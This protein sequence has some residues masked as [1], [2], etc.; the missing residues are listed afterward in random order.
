MARDFHF[1]IKEFIF[2]IEIQIKCI[3]ANNFVQLFYSS[4]I[5]VQI[6]KIF[7]FELNLI[8]SLFVILLLIMMHECKS[9]YMNA[10]IA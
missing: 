8:N 1:G 5:L 7:L 6:S 2:I 4:G 10:I 3:M 9:A